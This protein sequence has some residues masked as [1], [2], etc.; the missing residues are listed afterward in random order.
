MKSKDK[1]KKKA[2]KAKKIEALSAGG[3]CAP[4][5]PLYDLPTFSVQRGGIKYPAAPKSTSYPRGRGDS[6]MASSSGLSI[7]KLA[8]VSSLVALVAAGL[9]N[10]IFGHGGLELVSFGL[11]LHVG[12]DLLEDVLS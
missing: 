5:S 9:G 7:S 1:K 10:V 8:H 11:A 6:I 12:G 2:K 4:V 3:W